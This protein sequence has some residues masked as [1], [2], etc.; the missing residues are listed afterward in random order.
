MMRQMFLVDYTRYSIKLLDF[1]EDRLLGGGPR[2]VLQSLQEGAHIC[3]YVS[4]E[5]HVIELT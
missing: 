5:S 2:H 1:S 3:S 4:G